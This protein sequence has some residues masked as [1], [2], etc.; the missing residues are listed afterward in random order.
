MRR[1]ISALILVP[2]GVAV[3]VFALHNKGPLA[4]DLWPFGLTVEMPLYLVLALVLGAGVVLGGVVSWSGQGRVR[5]NLRDK[6]YE[7]EV[8]RRELQTERE[9]T[10]KLEKELAELKSGPSSSSSSSNEVAV[11]PAPETIVP[12][13]SAA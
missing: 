7:A 11:T 2:A 10:A 1:I 3:V 5:A 4:L 6:I 12:S 13:Q 8:A 9:T